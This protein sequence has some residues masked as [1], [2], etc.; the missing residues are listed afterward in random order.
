MHV[1]D[2]IDDEVAV[3]RLKATLDDCY[4]RALELTAR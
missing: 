2:R 1:D 4:A 3:A